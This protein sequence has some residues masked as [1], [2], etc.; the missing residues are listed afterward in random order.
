MNEKA[1]IIVVG[2]GPC[3]SFS[4]FAASRL[5]ADVLVCEEHREI[6]VPKHCAGHLSINGLK[7]LGLSLPHAV[8]ENEIKGA[9]FYSPS[10]KEFTIRRASPVT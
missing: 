7:R 5:G 4:A 10:G 1:D 3:G 6:G 8:I 2:G 9:I